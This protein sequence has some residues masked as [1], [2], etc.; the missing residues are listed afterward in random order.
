MKKLKLA[1]IVAVL[2]ALVIALVGCSSGPSDADV[3]R[4]GI[5]EEFASIKSGDDELLS[6]V[7]EGAGEDMQ[8]LGIDA[9]EFM[10]AYLDGFDYTI[11]DIKV[12]GDAA[13]VHISV[14]CRSMSDITGAFETAFT[15]ALADVDATDEDA[16][17]KLAGQVLM[18]CTKDAELKTSEFDVDC[19]KDSDGTWSYSDGVEDQMAEV[20]FS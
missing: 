13:T 20:F 19:E 5:D 10:A 2:A 15:D 4:Q 3:I 12:D 6:A 14:T 8:T 18:Q 9:K 17:Y 11:G 7:E 1:P 16:L